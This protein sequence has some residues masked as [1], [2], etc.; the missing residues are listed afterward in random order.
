M[1]SKKILL[2]NQKKMLLKNLG[3]HFILPDFNAM[4]IDNNKNYFIGNFNGA[5]CYALECEFMHTLDDCEWLPIKTAMELCSKEWFGVIARACQ[6]IEWDKNHQYC[7]KCGEKTTLVE[8]H[9][10]RRCNHCHLFFFSKISPAIIVLIKKENSL[11]MARKKEF[12][13]GVYALIA[14]FVEPGET[15]EETVHREAYEEVGIAVK[16]IVYAGS[17][18]WPF[19]DSLMV[20]FYADYAGGEI[21][22][23]DGEIEHADWY[24]ANNLPGFPSS[25]ISIAKKMIDDFCNGKG[26]PP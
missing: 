3:S 6:L 16:N 17:Q 10:E 1:P 21:C 7:G 13:E 18:S 9:F 26:S 14:G 12:P 15:F 23:N 8:N 24:D 20:A 5:N 22:Y 25:S 11:L 4:A 19:P 2:F